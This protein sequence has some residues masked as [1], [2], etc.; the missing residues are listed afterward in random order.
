VFMF[1]LYP[2]DYYFIIWFNPHFDIVKILTPQ[3]ISLGESNAECFIALLIKNK[4]GPVFNRTLL[5]G[6]YIWICFT[7]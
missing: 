2:L 1:L 5:F 7:N 3:R 4:K 6:N